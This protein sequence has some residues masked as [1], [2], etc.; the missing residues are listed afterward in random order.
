M[1]VGDRLGCDICSVRVHTWAR[2][3]SCLLTSKSHQQPQ[4]YKVSKRLSRDGAVGQGMPFITAGRVDE[5]VLELEMQRRFIAPSLSFRCERC[6]P[7]RLT[8]VCNYP[9]QS[10]EKY[11]FSPQ[12]L[13]HSNA[14][15]R[16]SNN[17]HYSSVFN[18]LGRF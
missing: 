2:Y 16:M 4:L 7:Q 15:L 5:V 13:P 17:C 18:T 14:S 10:N 6:R 9:K 3:P 8:A 11:Y 1:A 12:T